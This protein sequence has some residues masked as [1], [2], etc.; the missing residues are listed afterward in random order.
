MTEELYMCNIHVHT[1]T[2]PSQEKLQVARVSSL[3]TLRANLCTYHMY[4]TNTYM[5]QTV[6]GKSIGDVDEYASDITT[7]QVYIYTHVH[8]HLVVSLHCLCYTALLMTNKLGTVLKL[9]LY[10]QFLGTT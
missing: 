6:L 5:R 2:D 8:V 10:V 7:T 1:C 3:C 9:Y 4:M